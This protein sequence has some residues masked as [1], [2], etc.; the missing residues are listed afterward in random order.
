MIAITFVSC[1]AG[2]ASGPSGG[3]V[4]GRVT[5][6]PTCPVERAG[7]PCPPAPVSAVVQ[8][9]SAERVVAST[10]SDSRGRYALHVPAG[11]YTLIA[12]TKQRYPHCA[13]TRATVRDHEVTRAAIRCDT[14]IR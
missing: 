14:G 12:V 2:A 3:T 8:A 10:K 9:R 13:P 1:A 6:G 11:A 7:H 4:T 5:A